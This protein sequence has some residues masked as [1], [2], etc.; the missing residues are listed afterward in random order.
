M[1]PDRTLLVVG[2]WA[3]EEITVE[4]LKRAGD[5]S[6]AVYMDTDNPG[7]RAR[8]DDVRLGCFD[9]PAAL[10]AYARETAADLVLITTAAPL[11]A[12]AADALT[13]AGIPVFG[14]GRDAARLEFDKAWT[15]DLMRR[16]DVAGLPQFAVFDDADTAVARARERQ[17]QV[18]VKPIGLTDGLGVRVFGDQLAAS[19]DVEAYI[20]RILQERLSGHARVIVEEKLVGEE[21]TLQCLVSGQTVVPLPLAQDFKKL[22]PGERGPNT[23]SMGS[24]ARADGGLPFVTKADRDAALAIIRATLAAL[25]AEGASFTGFLYGQFMLTA[26]GLRLI[27]YNARPG[28]PEWM[29]TMAVMEDD[30]AVSIRAVMDGREVAPAFRPAAT[31]VK[32]LVPRGY[33]ETLD[34]ILNV[35]LDASRLAELGVAAYTSAGLDAEG[36]LNVGHERGIALVAEAP[37]VPEAHEKVE[38][39]MAAVEGDFYHRHDI[40]SP[41][42]L[43]RIVRHAD[44]LRSAGGRT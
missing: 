43:E 12:G 22:L 11:A 28:D 44:E 3:K 32:Y 5:T 13:E 39:A 36:H 23:A 21:F 24:Y 20:R 42:L 1:K 33:P 16:H 18:A 37:T 30:L 15:R 8:A 2:S 4:H 38:A 14:P 19:A 40:G 27:E 10:V 29:N 31:V 9:D 34:L 25:A 26:A 35:T 17:W 41:E 7:L 6:V